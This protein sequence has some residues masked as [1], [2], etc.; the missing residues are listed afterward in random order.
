M[1]AFDEFTKGPLTLE[2]QIKIIS[3]LENPEEAERVRKSLRF[4]EVPTRLKN[5]DN[6]KWGDLKSSLHVMFHYANPQ[7]EYE[8]N[9]MLKLIDGK[10]SLLEIGSNFGGTLKRMASVMKPGST[11]VSVDLPLDNTPPF[12][13]PQASLKV[14]CQQISWMGAEVELFIGNSHSPE[15]KEAVGQYG[16]FDVVFIDGDHSYEG[17]KQDWEDYGPMGRIVGFHDICDVKSLDGKNELGCHRFW[18]ELKA[19]GKYKTD[20]FIDFD[21]PRRFG[22]G[23]V[24]RE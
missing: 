18:E 17:V 12:L 2:E 15:V 14:S 10:S 3:L 24:Y 19:E 22:I 5:P 6:Y 21:S 20:E 8:F 9:E 13:N 11:I 7:N 16:P 23:I 1:D 4:Y